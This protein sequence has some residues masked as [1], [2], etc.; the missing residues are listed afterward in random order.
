MKYMSSPKRAAAKDIDF[1][2]DIADCLVQKYRIDI[3][4]G[5]IDSPLG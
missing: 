5:D 1:Y 4:K 2:I 3:G